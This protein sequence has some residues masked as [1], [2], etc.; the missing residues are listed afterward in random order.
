MTEP[1]VRKGMPPVKL[2]RDEF[3]KRYRAGLS[4][5]RS[6][7][8]SGNSMPSSARPGMPTAIPAKRR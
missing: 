8:L 3:E 1:D 4:I 6:Q 2:S 7:P 5:P